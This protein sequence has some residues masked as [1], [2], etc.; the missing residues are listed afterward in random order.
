MSVVR[1]GIG[2]LVI[3]DGK[4]LLGRRQGSHGAGYWAAPGGH[5][6]FGETPEACAARELA[7]E[8][9]L[10]A[11]HFT[12]APWTND[13]FAAEHKHYITLFMVTQQAQGEPQRCEPDKCEGW[14]WFAL[15]ALPEPLFA[16]LHTLLHV[17]GGCPGLLPEQP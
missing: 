17:N 1:V 14:H 3:R 7:E 15:N 5:L 12:A 16:P 6:E 9:G 8:T 11:S 10:Y 4:L 13:W 2:V